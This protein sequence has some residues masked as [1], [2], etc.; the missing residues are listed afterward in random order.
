MHQ[1]EFESPTSRFVAECSIQLSYWCISKYYYKTKVA[2]CQY[3]A[4]LENNYKLSFKNLTASHKE[5]SI[6]FLLKVDFEN[7]LAILANFLLISI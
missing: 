1:E 3:L 5:S 4:T 2:K 7:K 6:D